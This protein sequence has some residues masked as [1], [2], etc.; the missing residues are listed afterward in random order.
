MT[1]SFWLIPSQYDS[2]EQVWGV[3]GCAG[4]WGPAGLGPNDSTVAVAVEIGCQFFT[5]KWLAD[6]QVFERDTDLQ[7]PAVGFTPGFGLCVAV[8]FIIVPA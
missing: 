5:C 6:S 3:F 2:S 8:P 7:Y 4:D 1:A